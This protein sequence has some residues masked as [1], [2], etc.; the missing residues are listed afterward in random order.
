VHADFVDTCV[1]A[2]LDPTE[3]VSVLSASGLWV[4]GTDP[5]GAAPQ[6]T[7]GPWVSSVAPAGGGFVH[8]YVPGFGGVL[9]T[10]TAPSATG[11]WSDAAALGACDLPGGD[12]SAFCA[13][14]VAHPE[15]ADPARPGEM[16]VSYSIGSTGQQTGTAADYWPRLDWR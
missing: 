9:Q 10:H 5:S 2:R 3:G 16:V 8:V 1:L 13:G 15:L 7:S 14:P 12:A 11:P 4:Q 6:F